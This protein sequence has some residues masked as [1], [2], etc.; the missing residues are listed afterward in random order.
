MGIIDESEMRMR[1]DLACEKRLF[2]SLSE[3]ICDTTLERSDGGFVTYTET[4]RSNRV[5]H[6]PRGAI[7][8]KRML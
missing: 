3:E 2:L 5:E 1:R 7:E 4:E 8:D 6:M